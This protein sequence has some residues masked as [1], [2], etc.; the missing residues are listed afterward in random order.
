MTRKG[1]DGKTAG[2]QGSGGNRNVHYGPSKGRGVPIAGTSHRMKGTSVSHEEGR[3]AEH[4]VNTGG[5][6]SHMWFGTRLGEEKS[7]QT[8]E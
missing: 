5:K 2:N 4:K 6:G 1:K 8:F 3:W 7:K